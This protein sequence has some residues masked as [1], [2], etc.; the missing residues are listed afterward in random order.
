MMSKTNMLSDYERSLLL[1]YFDDKYYLQL[2]PDLAGCT[3]SLL[4]HYHM[5]GWRE[6]RNPNARFNTIYY[7]R[8]HPDIAQ[9]QIN[10]LLHYAM[11][12]ISEGRSVVRRLD[13]WRHRLEMPRDEKLGVFRILKGSVIQTFALQEQII[14]KLCN[15]ELVISVSHDDY[16]TNTGGIQNVVYDEQRAANERGWHYLHLSPA[17]HVPRLAEPVQAH[18]FEVGVRLDGE[19]I[20]LTLMDSII[21]LVG[22]LR[23][24]VNILSVVIHHMMSHCPELLAKLVQVSGCKVP[25]VWAHDFFYSCPSYTLLRNDVVF[26]GGPPVTST[27]CH[28]CRYGEERPS[29]MVR[30]K[31]FFDTIKP[32]LLAPSQSALETLQKAVQLP[33]SASVD[34]P[35]G[36]LVVGP[37]LH[38]RGLGRPGQPLRIAHIGGRQ[39]HKGWPHFEELAIQFQNDKRYEFFQLGHPDGPALPK[40]IDNI[41][42]SVTCN[43]RNRMVEAI[44][45]HSIDVA[46]VWSFWPETFCFT[47]YEALAGGA[48][49]ITHD[50]SGNVPKIVEQ[51]PEHGVVLH[52]FAELQSFLAGDKLT[53]LVG[54]SNRIRGAIVTGS[55][56]VG[57]ILKNVFVF[58]HH[59]TSFVEENVS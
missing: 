49:L 25:I 23:N 34:V 33:T 41:P 11:A 56:T 5:H 26:C 32:V 29:H 20:G 3:M 37:S 58:D 22:E 1:P 16:A 36:K 28:I 57:W 54:Q 17:Y 53:S 40:C 51:Y 45:E 8:C 44:S 19:F 35:I 59:S 4:E 21:H 27:A 13:A 55:N 15:A 52:D 18:S 12:G 10:P 6:G 38:R 2:Y 31:N 43:A 9:A 46:L 24:K 7:L 47:A 42:V 39:F 30:I 14:K 48:F 50:G